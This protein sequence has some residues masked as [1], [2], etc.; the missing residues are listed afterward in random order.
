[1]TYC[2]EKRD[3]K[4]VVRERVKEQARRGAG[5]GLGTFPHMGILCPKYKILTFFQQLA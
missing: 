2:R 3:T 4:N 1:M 5:G